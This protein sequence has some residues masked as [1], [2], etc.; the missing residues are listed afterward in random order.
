MK[1]VSWSQ[2]LFSFGKSHIVYWN[3]N[4]SR[5]PDKSEIHPQT[6]FINELYWNEAQLVEKKNIFLVNQSLTAIFKIFWFL[7][8][9]IILSSILMTDLPTNRWINIICIVFY[10]KKHATVLK[11]II[12]K[13]TNLPLINKLKITN[14]ATFK[15]V[16]CLYHG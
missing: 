8:I 14:N 9:S 11:W 16:P 7:I 6:I 1:N 2:I 15:I 4:L 10:T 3:C 12:C 5:F 13:I